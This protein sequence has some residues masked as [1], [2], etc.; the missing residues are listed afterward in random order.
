MCFLTLEDQTALLEAVL[1]PRVYARFG[2][3]IAGQGR[4][5]VRGTVEARE[6]AIALHAEALERWD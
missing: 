1:F 3:E 6:G 2:G 5:L 4:Y